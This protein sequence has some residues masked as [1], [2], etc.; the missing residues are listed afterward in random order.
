MEDRFKALYLS[1]L[2]NGELRKL[3]PRMKGNW[4]T[5]KNKFI[6]YQREL[7]TFANIKDV[8]IDE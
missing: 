4:E 8:D 3:V 6:S 5:D 7:E 2:E 1:L